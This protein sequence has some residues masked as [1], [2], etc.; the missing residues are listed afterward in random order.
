MGS[1]ALPWACAGRESVGRTSKRSESHDTVK[2]RVSASGGRH[3]WSSCGWSYQA[4]VMQPP[5][6]EMNILTI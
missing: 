2:C 4:E 6:A 5:F 3:G 1:T